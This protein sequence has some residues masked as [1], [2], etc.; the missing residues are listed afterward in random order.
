[1]Y[2]RPDAM[3]YTCRLPGFEPVVVTRAPLK[4]AQKKV[5]AENTENVDKVPNIQLGKGA[6]T[7]VKLVNHVFQIACRER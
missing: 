4:G 6:S 7:L 3:L 5:R 1:M 2:A